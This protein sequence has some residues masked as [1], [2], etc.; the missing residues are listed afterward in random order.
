MSKMSKIEPG[1]PDRQ[2]LSHEEGLSNANQVL[3]NFGYGINRDSVAAFLETLADYAIT[4]GDAV[5]CDRFI[6]LARAAAVSKRDADDELDAG[7]IASFVA[8]TADGEEIDRVCGI[9]G[10]RLI[11]IPCVLTVDISIEGDAGAKIRNRQEAIDRRKERSKAR[12]LIVARI[13]GD[14]DVTRDRDTASA[15]KAIDAAIL[16]LLAPDRFV[17]TVEVP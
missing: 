10:R 13:V 8:G 12:M 4:P 3:G 14:S 7:A 6:E 5:S 11:A 16:E 1:A 2:S 17:L 9:V 15:R